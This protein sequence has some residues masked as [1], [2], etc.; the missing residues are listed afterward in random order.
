MT[1]PTFHWLAPSVLTEKALDLPC[2]NQCSRANLGQEQR[3]CGSSCLTQPLWNT[4]SPRAGGGVLGPCISS[5]FQWHFSEHRPFSLPGTDGWEGR[6]P[7]RKSFLAILTSTAMIFRSEWT[8]ICEG[9]H[10][11]QSW[12]MLISH[13]SQLWVFQPVLGHGISSWFWWCSTW[14]TQLCRWG[15]THKH[16]KIPWGGKDTQVKWQEPLH[17]LSATN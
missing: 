12:L 10:S 14:A 1:S 9:K 11:Q 7:R 2:L 3:P 8:L 4:S 13:P 5:G 15:I 16:Y 6:A 17:L